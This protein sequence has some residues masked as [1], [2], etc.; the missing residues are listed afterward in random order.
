MNKIATTVLSTS[1][2]AFTFIGCGEDT[3]NTTTGIIENSIPIYGTIDVEGTGETYQGIITK[4]KI[5]PQNDEIFA[6]EA[7]KTQNNSNNIRSLS[8]YEDIK[9][10][11]LQ[12]IVNAKMANDTPQLRLSNR[13]NGSCGGDAIIDFNTDDSRTLGS[14]FF[15]DFCELGVTLNGYIDIDFPNL[16][17][18]SM[19]FNTLINDNETNT[20]VLLKD[21]VIE[22]HMLNDFNYNDFNMTSY[23]QIFHSEYGGVNVSTTEIFSVFNGV[24]YDG[25]LLVEGDNNSYTTLILESGFP[26]IESDYD[27]DGSIDYVSQ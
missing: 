23:G 2:I 22:T 21:F 18:L 8:N 9:Y 1:L 20:S 4:A 10:H 15:Q 19:N 6:Q 5:T 26:Y 27:G 13:L 25:K 12:V 3:S 7:L 16:S 17:E 14:M 24:A 11:L